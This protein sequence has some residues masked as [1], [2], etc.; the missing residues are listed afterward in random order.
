[1]FTDV[2][3]VA[4]QL[5]VHTG[6]EE[7]CS[8][9]LTLGGRW[10]HMGLTLHDGEDFISAYN[11]TP[12]TGHTTLRLICAL[13]GTEGLGWITEHTLGVQGPWCSEAKC[14]SWP[15]C[16]KPWV[17][18]QGSRQLAPSKEAEWLRRRVPQPPCSNLESLRVPQKLELSR[19]QNKIA[20]PEQRDTSE[21]L[22]L[23]QREHPA[24]SGMTAR[25]Q[26]AGSGQPP[27][28]AFL[29][30]ILFIVVY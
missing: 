8:Q 9:R 24:S 7:L 22:R 3:T 29:L 19:L 13:R 26:G 4:A 18:S 6:Q 5:G 16:G 14:G 27:K 2:H 28:T 30:F 17:S 1:M 10:D 15:K 25:P 11:R 20:M 12:P 21:V 23:F